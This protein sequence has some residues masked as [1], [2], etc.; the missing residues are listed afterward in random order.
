MTWNVESAGIASGRFSLLLVTAVKAGFHEH[1]TDVLAAIAREA[2]E[3]MVAQQKN[4][5]CTTMNPH[6]RDLTPEVWRAG[7]A[8]IETSGMNDK[9]GP[10]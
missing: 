2:V 4:G 8:L 3:K 6:W 7:A 10:R 5:P 1:Y 9:N